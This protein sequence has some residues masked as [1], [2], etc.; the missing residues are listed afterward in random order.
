MRSSL[1]RHR[2]KLSWSISLFLL[3]SNAFSNSFTAT[4]YSDSI[5]ETVRLKLNELI[6]NKNYSFQSLKVNS[7]KNGLT[8]VGTFFKKPGVGFTASYDS[9]SKK[10]FFE[11]R[12]P[13]NS[14]VGIGNRDA[15]DLMGKSLKDLIPKTLRS[16]LSL[17]VFNFKFD[18]EDKKISEVNLTFESLKDL[19]LLDFNAFRL[20]GIKTILTIEHPQDSQKKRTS[21][22]LE[23]T[24]GIAGKN[25][26]FTAK[27]K[28]NSDAL[29]YIGK[30]EDVDFSGTLTSLLGDWKLGGFSLPQKLFDIKLASTELSIIPAKKSIGLSSVSTF[31]VIS[32][33]IA[34]K[35]KPKK[36]EKDHS[37]LFMIEP[38]KDA[39]LSKISEHLKLL[40]NIDLSKQVLVL[41]SEKKSKSEKDKTPFKDKISSGVKKGLNMMASID[42]TKIKLDHLIGVK[43]MIVSAPITS[44][45]DN[46]VLEGDINTNI[47]IGPNA[48]LSNAVFRLTPSPKDFSV[49]ILGEMHT[50]ISGDKLL[51]RGGVELVL[52]DQ[53]MNFMAM[54][55]G[56]WNDPLGARGLAVKDLGIQMGASFTTTPIPLPNVALTG[57]V[58]IGD[59]AGAASVSFDSRN[60]SKNMLALQYNKI[61]LLD[62]VNLVTSPSIRRN[63]SPQLQKTLRGFYSENVVI[64]SVPAP[65]QVLET[66]YEPGF[67]MQGTIAIVG[68]KGEAGFDMDYDNGMTAHGSVDPIKLAIFELK[69][70]N[71]KPKPGFSL[72]I[73]RNK[74]PVV[75]LNGGV[76]LLG[77]EAATD[78]HLVDNGYNFMVNG[79][80]FNL[81]QGAIA[82]RGQ[83]L[84]KAVDMQ[85]NVTMQNDFR[86]FIENQLKNYVTNATSESIKKLQKAQS[87]VKKAQQTVDSWSANV[88]QI[89]Q[90]VIKDQA[91][92]R[93]KIQK[94]RDAVNAA[95]RK[96]DGLN[97]TLRKLEREK[98][99]YKKH[100]LVKLS[101]VN[102][103]IASTKT[104]R[105]TATKTL[106]GAKHV[107]NGLT[108]LN[109]DPEKDG[110]LISARASHRS[111]QL[112][113]E[114]T[115]KTMDGLIWSLGK[116]GK[117]AKFIVEKG[118]DAV[119]NIRRASFAGALGK[120]HGAKV[121]LDIEL[122]WMN[123]RETLRM[124]FDFYNTAESIAGMGKSLLEK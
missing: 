95:Q 19:K 41:S 108:K 92:D 44:K 39:K 48:T 5:E 63:I 119:V 45:L 47:Q 54:M 4:P 102:T 43:D 50:N 116:T 114:G 37:Y 6:G 99:G 68:V 67:R 86:N 66:Y 103:K 3:S 34:K 61:E 59:F 16:S 57:Q 42:L 120:V 79:K 53:T 83:D 72:S 18:K 106:N 89:R 21:G 32:G 25:V 10:T 97:N 117:A 7:E 29:E 46:V 124:K 96:V 104:A 110:R 90:L 49:S 62:L 31:G 9:L 12:L 52:T 56:Q 84:S 14:K 27:L 64:E 40:D 100:Q 78:V 11:L 94:A 75:A 101:A 82:A 115:Q 15:S 35:A 28:S 51:F 107:L 98:A 73:E 70:A 121:D 105:F 122:D 80:V 71:G 23:G 22:I 13:D 1:F 109:I 93:A 81:F 113:L 76:K 17:R 58:F 60:P 88:E 38:H 111:A 118:S 77:V 55:E 91:K 69:G 24:T 20:K 26:L 8:G 87:N 74:R 112:T 33:H 36:G 123:K 65:M 85:L 2:L 30:V